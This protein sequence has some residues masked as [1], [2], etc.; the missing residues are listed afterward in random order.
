M[1]GKQEGNCH[2]K[3][4]EGFSY[5][6]YIEEGKGRDVSKPF[7]AVTCI[8]A[9]IGKIETTVKITVSCRI[10]WLL[11]DDACASYYK[12]SRPRT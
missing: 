9:A 6:T 2:C 3:V 1:G 4:R 8:R 5:I 12:T 7:G 11:V 10:V